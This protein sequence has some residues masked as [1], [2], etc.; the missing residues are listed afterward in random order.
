[1]RASLMAILLLALAGCA[2]P[3]QTPSETYK[4]MRPTYGY[5]EEKS[6]EDTYKV[7]FRGYPS[8]EA[9]VVRDLALLRAAELAKTSGYAYFSVIDRKE[10]SESFGGASLNKDLAQDLSGTYGQRTATV[11]AT[12]GFGPGERQLVVVATVRMFKS[13]RDSKAPAFKVADVIADIC[14]RRDIRKIGVN[15]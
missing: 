2:F 8:T 12:S 15:S 14:A 10:V 11:M 13:E 3:I 7:I 5:S 9:A 4:A 6:A 1:M